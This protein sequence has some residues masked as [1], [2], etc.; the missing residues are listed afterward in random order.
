MFIMSY[1]D[2]EELK[3][4]IDEEE[5]EDLPEDISDEEDLNGLLD[6]DLLDDDLIDDDDL[7]IVDDTIDE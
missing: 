2:D 3:I 7:K 6:D 5:D 4:D 1:I